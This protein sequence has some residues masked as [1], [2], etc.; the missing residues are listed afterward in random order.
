VA[1]LA[2]EAVATVRRER[3]P[4]VLEFFTTRVRGHYEGDS[5]RYRNDPAPPVDPLAVTRAL[6]EERGAP[7]AELEALAEAIRAEVEAAVE[8]AQRSPEPTL[9]SAAEEVYAR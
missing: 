8:A 9:Q 5:Q 4:I 2:A 7:A 1:A 3:R 6:L